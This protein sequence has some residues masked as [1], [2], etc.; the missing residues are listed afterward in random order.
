[1]HHFLCKNKQTK[2]KNFF[3]LFLFLCNAVDNLT[4]SCLKQNMSLHRGQ[5]HIGH[6]ND[7]KLP[8]QFQIKQ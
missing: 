7:F 4:I 8:S 1:M 5:K 6:R 2:K 3:N